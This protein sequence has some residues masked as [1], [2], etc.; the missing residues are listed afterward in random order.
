MIRTHDGSHGPDCYGCRIQTVGFA[1][2]AMP[3]RG[4]NQTAVDTNAREGRWNKDMP[5]YKR[6]RRDGLQPERID[7]SA[8]LEARL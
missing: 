1:P 3:S 2:S 4:T 6:L 5:A 7:G 8:T